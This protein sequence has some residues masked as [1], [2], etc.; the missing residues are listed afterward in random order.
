MQARINRDSERTLQTMK[1][2]VRIDEDLKAIMNAIETSRK[3]VIW[4]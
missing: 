4:G 1:A 2:K 3:R